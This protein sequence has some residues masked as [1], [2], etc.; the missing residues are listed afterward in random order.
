MKMEESEHLCTVLK[1]A[2]I[3]K[4][5][6]LY[7]FTLC[8]QL[9]ISYENNKKSDRYTFDTGLKCPLCKSTHGTWLCQTA[10][11]TLIYIWYLNVMKL[12]CH[13]YIEENY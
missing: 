6:N 10:I 7:N 8:M 11:P 3:R 12:I 9:S 5:C 1:F 4:A 13:N 2:L